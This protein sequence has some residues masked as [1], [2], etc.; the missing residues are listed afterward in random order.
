MLSV[1][2]RLAALGLALGSVAS[3]GNLRQ[4]A[5][6]NRETPIP[7][8]IALD[9]NYLY[10]AVVSMSS[11]LQNANPETFYQIYAMV[12]GEFKD[13]SRQKLG[14]LGETFAENCEFNFVNMADAFNDTA[15]CRYLTKVCYFRL[16]IP[17]MLP[18]T[19]HK[20]I[21]TD[22]DTVICKDLTELF[23]FDLGDG[24]IWEEFRII[25]DCPK[26]NMISL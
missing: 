10:P 25:K 7:I 4:D 11:M 19:V 3:C 21:Y 5:R 16:K 6:A 26:Y 18:A 22:V 13:E 20:C 17:S 8:V 14:S 15:V 24:G 23:E 1:L 12:P 9:D 2:K